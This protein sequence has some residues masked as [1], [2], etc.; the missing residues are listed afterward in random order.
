MAGDTFA[1]PV[2]ANR[3]VIVVTVPEG[4]VAGQVVEVAIGREEASHARG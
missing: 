1:T 3:P 4:A 2:A